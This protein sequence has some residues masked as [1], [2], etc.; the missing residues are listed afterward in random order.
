MMLYSV[1]RSRFCIGIS[2]FVRK[3]EEEKKELELEAAR[4]KIDDYN[5]DINIMVEERERLIKAL[6]QHG[7]HCKHGGHRV[8]SEQTAEKE[9]M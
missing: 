7:R 4:K 2:K 1:R 9:S 3:E 8:P 6:D 5:R